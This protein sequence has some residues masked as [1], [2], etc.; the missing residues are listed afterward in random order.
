MNIFATRSHQPWN[1]GMAAWRRSEAMREDTEAG[2][3][4]RLHPLGLLP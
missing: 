4:R 1:K 3:Q 2:I